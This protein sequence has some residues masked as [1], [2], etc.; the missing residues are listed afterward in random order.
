ML[1]R[2]N[3]SY[4][5]L[6]ALI[7]L[8]TAVHAQTAPAPASAGAQE[9]PPMPDA[10]TGVTEGDIIVTAQRQSQGLQK[11]PIAVSAFTAET[12]TQQQI[13]NPLALQQTLPSV[14]FTKTNFSGGSFTIRGIGDLCV[15]VTCDQATAAHV[16]DMP[17]QD[18]RMFDAEF[19]DM[20]RIE[21]L[22]GPQG[23]LFG[24]NATSG[25]VNFITARPGFAAIGAAGEVE[26]GNF[27]SKRVR[28]MLNLPL[29]D[30]IAVRVAGTYLNRDGFTRNRFDGRDID[31]R[32]LYGVRGTVSWQPGASTR[33]DVMAYYSRENDDRA[34]VQKQLCHRDP[35]GILGCLPD[36]LGNDVPNGNA[37]I[38]TIATSREFLSLAAPPLVPFALGSVYGSDPNLGLS[39]PA[40]PR[41]VDVDV[42]PTYRA[43]EQQYVMKLRQDL[44]RI[45]LTVTGGYSSD[46]LA[47]TADL[48]LSTQRPLAGNAGLVA[49]DTLA[50]PGSPYAFL[51]AV[52]SRLI[53]NGAGGNVCQSALD[54]S[55]VGLF[56]GRSVG[57]TPQSLDY[58]RVSRSTRT[59]S[60]EV[61]V[62]SDWE[63]VFNFLAGA[64][65]F[66]SKTRNSFY[67]FGSFG[68]D[69]A[70]GLLGSAATAATPGVA[71]NSYLISPFFN[72]LGELFT[73]KSYG[74]F[75]ETYWSFGD[76]FKLTLGARYN[77]D[78][79]YLGARTTI[80]SVV[81]P[82]GAQRIQDGYNF[83]S[84]D[85]DPSLAGI[86]PLA[87]NR[88]RFGRVTGRAVLEYQLTS[89]NMLYASYARGYKSG[90]IN[91]PAPPEVNV[92][93]TF[94]PESV[95]AF[96]IGSKN[97]ML[98]GQLR[99]NLTG[100][101]LSLPQSPARPHGRA[102]RDQRQSQRRHL[103]RGA[104]GD[105][106]A[107]SA[108]RRQH[109]CQLPAK[110]GA[111]RHVLPRCPRSLGRAQ[112]R[113]RHQGPEQ[114]LQLRGRGP[115]RRDARHGQ[116][117]RRRGQRRARPR[118]PRR[119][120]RPDRDGRLWRLLGPRHAIG[121]HRR[122]GRG[123]GRG[124]AGQHPRAQPAAGAALQGVG[125]R[126][127]SHPG[128]IGRCRDRPARRSGLYQR[129][130]HLGV[131]RPRRPGQ[132]LCDRQRA[133]AAQPRGRTLLSARLRPQPHQQQ[134]DHRPVS[135]RPVAG[136]VHQRL[137]AGTPPVRHR[138][139]V[140]ILGS[141]VVK[142][143]I[144]VA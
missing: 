117:L 47:S 71:G 6:A 131:Q 94:A 72:N 122:A 55:G 78:E 58:E 77:H 99:L 33:I 41:T 52:R 62:D 129:T 7:L 48:Y 121:G 80:L 28:G 136:P 98:G 76:G 68:L 66:D 70:S 31:G 102:D 49:L 84:V 134:R 114:R 61:H 75:G 11:V 83:T 23:T 12:L 86:Q 37:L 106:H 128:R 88:A 18:T 143:Q 2:H 4:G 116:R 51:G 3:C 10:T 53:P 112:R 54:P 85:F 135:G 137:H 25:V 36:R 105:R 9:A 21:V 140:Q 123:A 108:V 89:R 107:G 100:L 139:R 46:T 67:G 96:E 14:T 126:A 44:G 38:N 65:Y 17:L 30:T 103:W 40:D 15:G 45:A 82:I 63:G 73:L 16:N 42:A 141:E 132:R 34:R 130:L 39:N 1:N 119:H 59:Y 97:S 91:P 133:G 8:P 81:A 64:I 111:G 87:V 50:R 101:L 115:Q 144:R 20:E 127:I 118:R 138:R 29:S 79:K 93:A 95:D 43:T 35:T 24:R 110:Q 5:V 120:P 90:G 27:D 22:R 104:G 26:Y 74:L 32:D 142:R 92:G 19:F 60:A 13:V 124:R 69:Y 125:R 57:C 56:G 109:Q 113:R